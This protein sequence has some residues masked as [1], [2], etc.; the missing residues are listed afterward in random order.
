VT[1]TSQLPTEP[2]LY[3]H[4][5]DFKGEMREQT[6]FVGYTNATAPKLQGTQPNAYMPRKLKCCRPEEHLHADRL[7]PAEW[8]GWWERAS[9]E[10]SAATCCRKGC[11]QPAVNLGGECAEHAR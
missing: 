10:T 7:T 3:R 4:R 1:F 5:W 9:E 11:D 2:G 6:L 8:G